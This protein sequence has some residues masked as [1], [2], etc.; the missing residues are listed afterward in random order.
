MK[1]KTIGFSRIGAFSM[2]LGAIFAL[3]LSLTVPAPVVAKEFGHGRPKGVDFTSLFEFKTQFGSRLDPKELKGR[4]FVVAFGFTHCPDV[5]P[6]T[7]LELANQMTE[8]GKES[9]RI[10]VLFVTL[11]PERDTPEHLKS[12]LASFD[13]RFIGLS[14]SQLDLATLTHAFN[15]D[16]QKVDRPDG[17]Y[18]IDHSLKVAFV[19]R[20]GLLAASIDVIKTPSPKTSELLRRLLAQ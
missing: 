10:R 15:I 13:S 8:L 4:P 7:L 19:D 9:D 1:R 2:A 20:Y 14:G 5:C 12:Y 6:T 16:F 18:T 3:T 17:R 11:D